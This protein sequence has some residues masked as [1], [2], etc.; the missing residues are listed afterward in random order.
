MALRD[1]LHSFKNGDISMEEAEKAL[2]M[3]YVEK[4]N[5]HTVFDHSR[6]I[7]KDVPEVVY[8]LSKTP[9]TVAEIAKRVPEDGY[10]LISR[11]SEEHYRAVKKAVKG[12]VVKYHDVA[13]VISVGKTPD[14]KKKGKIGILTAGT[15]DI[16]VAEEARLMTETMGCACITSYDVGVA[17]VHR[18]L[19]PMKEM[20]LE[21]VDAMIVI[22]GM[23]GAL[24]SLVASLSSV[25]VIGVPTSTGYGCGGKGEAALMC[26]LQT[27]SPGLAVVNIDNGIGAAAMAVMISRQRW[28]KDE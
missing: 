5:G 3:D 12:N 8:A 24:P 2:R 21:D 28:K 20:L 10:L 26:M 15:S 18:V 25:P 16:G 7:R 4:V 23:E 9:E 14:V 13:S 17:G 1:I 19:E 6:K 11:A 22:A 27:C